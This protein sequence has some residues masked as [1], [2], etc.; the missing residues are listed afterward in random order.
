MTDKVLDL[1]TARV[2]ADAARAAG[3]RVVLAN[4]C[5]DLLHVGHVRYLA[6]AR[7]LGDLLIVGLN[8]D[9]SVRRLKGPGRPLMPATERAELVAALAAV[10]HV[11]VFDDDTADRLVTVLRPAVHAKGTDYTRDS[12]PEAATVQASGGEVAIAGDPKRHSTRDLI[13]DILA[14][15]GDRG[16]PRR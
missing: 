11:V 2:V 5:F 8:S 13:A 3:H 7:A 12:V 16:A 4:G 6:A 10:N 14:R 9:A 15:F 1:E